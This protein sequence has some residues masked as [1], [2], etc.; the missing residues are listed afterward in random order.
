[1]EYESEDGAGSGCHSAGRRSAL[2]EDAGADEDSTVD[3]AAADAAADMR[4]D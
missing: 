3:A 2:S 4:G 1:M